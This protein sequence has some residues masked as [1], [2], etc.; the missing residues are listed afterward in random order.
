M[1]VCE[2]GGFDSH[3]DRLDGFLHWI[4]T[5]ITVF[6]KCKCFHK[7]RIMLP[8]TATVKLFIPNQL[9][10]F[11][12]YPSSKVVNSG[13]NW[14]VRNTDLVSDDWEQA[15]DFVHWVWEVLVVCYTDQ[16]GE[17]QV[18]GGTS[19]HSSD[20]RSYPGCDCQM[21]TGHCPDQVCSPGAGH[22]GLCTELHE[23]FWWW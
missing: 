18:V 2:N 10:Y 5:F 19:A 21:C 4:S 7:R 8:P 11:F 14:K 17:A 3:L 13:C 16:V 20:S 9:N 1:C 12:L 23:W 6:S 22:L 15:N